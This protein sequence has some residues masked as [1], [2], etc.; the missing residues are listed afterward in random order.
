MLVD[1]SRADVEGSNTSAADIGGRCQPW[2]YPKYLTIIHLP[3]EL[4]DGQKELQTWKTQ[5]WDTNLLLPSKVMIDGVD[6][7][8]HWFEQLKEELKKS[9]DDN[10]VLSWGRFLAACALEEAASTKILKKFYNR[11]GH[12]DDKIQAS[13]ALDLII[14]F[15]DEDF[16]RIFGVN[17]FPSGLNGGQYICPPCKKVVCSNIL[18]LDVGSPSPQDVKVEELLRKHLQ[19][20]DKITCKCC[21]A[22]CMVTTLRL[23]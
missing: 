6:C 10:L 19:D 16:H 1:T 4:N 21:G 20:N 18:L 17:L 12:K 14:K 5:N 15:L 9:D 7:S 11:V 13:N 8:E 22:S 2:G 3:L 23:N